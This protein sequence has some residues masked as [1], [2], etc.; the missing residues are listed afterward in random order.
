MAG[1]YSIACY[2]VFKNIADKNAERDPNLTLTLQKAY[3]EMTPEVY[4]GFRLM[5]TLISFIIALIVGIIVMSLGIAIPIKSAELVGYPLFFLI[6]IGIPLITYIGFDKYPGYKKSERAK[7]IDRNIPYSATFVAA[8]A[9]SNAT[10]ETTFRSLARQGKIYGAVADDATKI[11]RDMSFLGVDTVSA[12]KQAVQRAASDKLAEFFQGIVSTITSGGNLKL[13][14]LNRSEYFMIENRREQRASLDTLA[15]IAESYIVVAVAFPMFLLV[16]LVIM[17]WIGNSG[18][19]DWFLYLLVF[20]M[21]PMIH[22]M[23][24]MMVSSM[25]AKV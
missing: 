11:Y 25:G 22:F 24:S 8:M 19:P 21:F 12:L 5:N 15:L 1:G 20:G 9:A 4:I 7:D 3:I 23:Y 14:F 10:I 18:F 13:Y 2:N 16:M 6:I 17:L